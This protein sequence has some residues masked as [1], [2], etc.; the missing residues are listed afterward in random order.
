M[1]SEPASA[2]ELFLELCEL[3]QD[4]SRQRLETLAD[5][6]PGLAREVAELL[7]FDGEDTGLGS[8]ESDG[9]PGPLPEIQGFRVIR[10]IGTGGMGVVYEAEQ[11]HPQRRVALKLIRSGLMMPRLLRRFDAEIQILGRLRHPGIAQ[12]YEAGVTSDDDTGQPFYSMELI[13]GSKITDYVREKDL[14]ISQRVE[15]LTYVCDAV[16]HA[17]LSG[18]I[19]RDLKPDNVLIQERD[20]ASGS[21]SRIP[22]VSRWGVGTFCVQ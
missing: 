1:T 15:L 5:E 14:T 3:S 17:H 12:I 16:Q 22:V 8:L 6:H 11:I 21:E 7:D 13:E 10:R 18:V 19:H 9:V 20:E 2:K 4:E